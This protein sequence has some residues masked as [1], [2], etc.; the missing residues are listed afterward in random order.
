MRPYP[1]VSAAA[2]AALVAGLVALI[3]PAGAAHAQLAIDREAVLLNPTQPAERVAEFVVQNSGA[4]QLQATVNLQDW[5]VDARG[6]SHWRKAGHVAGSCGDRVSVSPRVL[7][8]APG[9][10][11]TV[12]VTVSGGARFD[13]ECWSAAVVK[14]S[15]A[16][17]QGSTSVPVY[18]TP[19]GAAVNGEVQDMFVKGDSLEIVFANTGNV[20]TEIVGEV[21]V[22][23]AGD[24]VVVAVPIENATV[25]AGATRR[26]R[27]AIPKVARGTYTLFAVVDFGGSELTA[28]QAAFEVR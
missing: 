20:R 26:F 16:S 8:L 17:E 3:I 12:Q 23:A 4:A 5:D 11:Q 19:A 7:R 24:S 6:A 21:Q 28:A 2:I 13:A 25:M 18:V 15:E 1:S 9:E 27:V 22:R 14:P 10:R